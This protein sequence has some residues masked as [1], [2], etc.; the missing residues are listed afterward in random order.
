[1]K[2]IF[3]PLVTSELVERI[4]QLKPESPALWGE[5]S[6]DQMLA[7]CNVAYEM[8]FTNKHPKPNALMRF[9]LKSFVKKG[10]VNE[11]PYSKNIRTAPAF[12]IA[13]RRDFQEEKDRLIKYLEHTLALGRDHF[14]GKE[15][16]SFGKMTAQEW[17]N[18]FYKHLDHHLTQFGV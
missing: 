6:V 5:M 7:H 10:V 2:N 1:M 14:E 13:D 4:N 18:Q 15:S 16:L 11:V 17:N 9:L 3:D 8:A 12:I